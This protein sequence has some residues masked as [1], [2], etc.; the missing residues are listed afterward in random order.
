MRNHGERFRIVNVARETDLSAKRWTVD[1]PRDIAFVRAVLAEM[2]DGDWDC[3]DLLDL[4]ARRPDI[5]AIN[6]GI[7]RDEGLA[8]SKKKDQLYLAELE[9]SKQDNADA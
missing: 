4:L 1:D 3:D 9:R 5:E 8:I 2:G 6:S 7:V